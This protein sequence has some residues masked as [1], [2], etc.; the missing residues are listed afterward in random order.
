MLKLPKLVSFFIVLT[1]F[2]SNQA[3]TYAADQ[4]PLEIKSEAAVL[5]DS[6]TGAILYSKNSD[7]RLYPASLTKIATAIYAIENGNIDLFCVI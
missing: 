1:L 6:E 5:L 4:K 7:E 3:N 2:L